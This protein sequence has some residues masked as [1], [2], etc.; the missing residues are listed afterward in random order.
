MKKLIASILILICCINLLHAQQTLKEKNK[1]MEWWR[2][3]KFGLFI[4]WGLYAVPAGTWKGERI[5]GIGEWIMQEEKIP[6]SDYQGIAKEFNPVKFNADEWVAA[7][8][9]AGMKYIVI[10]AKHHD[11]FAMFKS[12]AS[13]FNIVDATPFKRDPLKELAIACKKQG[14]KLGFYYSHAQDWNHAGGAAKGGH[15]DTA[16]DGDMDTYINNV[17]APQV[18]ELLTNYGPVSVIFWDTP[19]DMTEKRAQVLRDQL[20]IQ[21]NIIQN[22]RLIDGDLGDYETPEQFI[23]SIGLAGLDWEGNMTM[24]GTWGYKSYDTG[25]KSSKTIITNL[26]NI[27]SKGGNYLLNVGPDGQGLIPDSSLKRLKQVGAWMSTNGEAVYGSS[28]SPLT[29]QPV[30]GKCTYKPGKLY[31]TVTEWPTAAQQYKVTLPIL[32]G[33]KKAYLLNNRQVDLPHELIT[34]GITITLPEKSPDAIAGVICLEIDGPVKNL[35]YPAI[36][37]L[38]D[39]TIVLPSYAAAVVYRLVKGEEN[40]RGILLEWKASINTPGNYQMILNYDWGP[41]N[42]GDEYVF[43][44]GSNLLAGKGGFIKKWSMVQ[45]ITFGNIKI[46]QPG[47]NTFT[48]KSMINEGLGLMRVRSITL[49]PVHE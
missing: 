47:M 41:G 18:K 13:S 20:K 40:R 48:M 5:G 14:I 10:T 16:Q 21:P 3:A 27:A 8:K 7:A 32:N 24:N 33:I 11:G 29:R 28:A 26:V 17:A 35:T 19:F 39:G 12:N 31:I 1:K 23:P 49:K 4:H 38:A 22:D 45:N 34:D 43:A 2:E 30:W 37:P 6:V 36:E 9:G 42:N 46:E 25:W 44:T 15:W